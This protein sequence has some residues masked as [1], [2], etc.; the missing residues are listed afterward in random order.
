MSSARQVELQ[1]I[2]EG[3]KVARTLKL[4]HVVLETDCQEAVNAINSY[5]YEG[6]VSLLRS[7]VMGW[8]DWCCFVGSPLFGGWVFYGLWFGIWLA[9]E[10]QLAAHPCHSASAG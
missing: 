9:M 3:L 2:K 6:H 7:V 8:K 5:Y 1:A 10:H 4:Q